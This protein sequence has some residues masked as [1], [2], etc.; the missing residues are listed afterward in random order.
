MPNNFTSSD[1]LLEEAISANLYNQLIAQLIKDFDLAN[2]AVDFSLD[3]TAHDLRSTLHEKIYFLILERFSDYLNLLY[4]I[5]V[6]ERAFKDIKVT[7][8]VE[9]AEQVSFLILKRE[10]QKVNYKI[11]NA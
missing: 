1:E 9:I 2:V 5:D 10:L 8:V 4:V 7:D 11:N 6:P 3:V